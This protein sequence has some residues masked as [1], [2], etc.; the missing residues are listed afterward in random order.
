MEISPTA[1]FRLLIG[2]ML[3]LSTYFTADVE[4]RRYVLQGSASAVQL[5]D[6]ATVVIE[7]PIDG[8]ELAVQHDGDALTVR[9]LGIKTFDVSNEPE[10][11]N[12][13]QRAV[14]ALQ[15]YSGRVA[16]VHYDERVLDGADRLVARIEVDGD[17]LGA[18]LVREGWALV[19]TKYPF[20]AMEPYQVL[21]AEAE[22]AHRGL[23]SSPRAAERARL[24]RVAWEIQP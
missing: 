6:G 15:R 18:G 14:D 7:R 5:D 10:L 2:S 12:P 21:E 1:A 4:Y 22:A 13:G 17:D 11:G 9:L 24:M 8:D 16:V 23:W 20:A 19:Y 3:L